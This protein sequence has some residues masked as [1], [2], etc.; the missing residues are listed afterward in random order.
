MQRSML[1]IIENKLMPKEEHLPVWQDKPFK[2]S[3]DRLKNNLAYFIAELGPRANKRDRELARRLAFQLN[4]EQPEDFHFLDT[5]AWVLTRL[6][7]TPDDLK[8][9]RE[10]VSKLR[11]R[12]DVDKELK[13]QTLAKYKA[14]S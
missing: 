8:K 7:I 11:N 4:Q 6:A 9:S 1:E 10:I 14:V 12:L 13:Q 5:L 3:F 2:E